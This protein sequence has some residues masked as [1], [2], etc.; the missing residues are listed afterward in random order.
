MTDERKQYDYVARDL[1]K[2]YAYHNI[3]EHIVDVMISV[4]MHRDGF[5]RGGSFVEAI[6]DN[7]LDEACS[8]ADDDCI[9][10]L[11]LFSLVKQFGHIKN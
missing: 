5:Q 3:S 7:K 11:R 10:Y 2:R 1:A 6:C 9:N 4:M 8:R